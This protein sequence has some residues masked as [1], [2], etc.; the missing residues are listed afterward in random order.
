MQV[1]SNG[2]C[3]RTEAEWRQVLARYRKSGQTGR[4]FCR[5][6][7]IQASSFQR[8]RRRLERSASPVDFVT[9]TP[10]P[11]EA[12]ERSLEMTLPGIGTLRFQGRS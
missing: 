11:V 4:E 10:A 6:E 5:Q 8:W 12:K 2:R 7:G 9:L 1:L 3:R